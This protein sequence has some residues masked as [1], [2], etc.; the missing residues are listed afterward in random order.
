MKVSLSQYKIQH[1]PKIINCLQ[2]PNILNSRKIGN[3]EVCKAL[4]RLESGR[5]T[6]IGR[7]GGQGGDLLFIYTWDLPEIDETRKLV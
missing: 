2:K 6:V 5:K 7:S 3:S 4:G 1:F